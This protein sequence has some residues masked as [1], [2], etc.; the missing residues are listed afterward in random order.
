MVSA[1]EQPQVSRAKLAVGLLIVGISH[2]G[3]IFFTY[4]ARVLTRSAFWSSDFIVFVL[5]TLLAFAAYISLVHSRRTSW[6]L[7]AILSIALTFLSCWL[8]LFIAFN[9]YGT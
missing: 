5:P 2:V 3:Y 4:R 6:L 9:T 8:S 1:F 7:A